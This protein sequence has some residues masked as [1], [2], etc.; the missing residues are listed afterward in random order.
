MVPASY[1]LDLDIHLDGGDALTG[2]GHLEV[3]VAQE[4]LEALDVGEHGDVA[5]VH[6]LD[7]AHG[8]AGHHLLDGHARVHEGQGAGADAGLGVSVTRSL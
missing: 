2:T 1:A 4:V 8:H 5:G 3:H 7:E 6:V